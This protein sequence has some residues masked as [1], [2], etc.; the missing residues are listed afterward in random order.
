MKFKDFM[1]L[2][3]KDKSINYTKLS[4]HDKFL[5]R[6]NAPINTISYNTNSKTLTKEQKETLKKLEKYSNQLLKDVK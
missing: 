5:A 2:S 1:K 3:D 6:V 4:P